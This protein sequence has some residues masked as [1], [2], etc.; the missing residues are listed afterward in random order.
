MKVRIYFNLHRGGWSIQCAKTRRV[1]NVGT[2]VVTCAL[3]NARFVVSESGRQRVLKE[4][5]KNVHAVVEGDLSDFKLVGYGLHNVEESVKVTYNPYHG[6]TFYRKDDLTPV[7][8]AF[9]VRFEIVDGKPSVTAF[10]P[11]QGA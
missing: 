10:D 4:K 2:K 9:G 1:L 11:I 5:R 3:V 7:R 8:F 6:S